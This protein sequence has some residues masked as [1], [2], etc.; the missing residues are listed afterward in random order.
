[1]CHLYI[2]TPKQGTIQVQ[3]QVLILIN[4]CQMCVTPQTFNMTLMHLLK[5]KKD[6]IYH[7]IHYFQHRYKTITTVDF[8][9]LARPSRI[10]TA[11]HL[12]L[13]KK[14]LPIPGIRGQRSQKTSWR[15]KKTYNFLY[16]HLFQ[17]RCLECTTLLTVLSVCKVH[18]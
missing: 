6:Y 3:I 11:S 18:F 9:L 7:A 4:I 15:P 17:S 12:V 2:G 5:L 8:K 1:M 10:F 14:I 16:S 13:G